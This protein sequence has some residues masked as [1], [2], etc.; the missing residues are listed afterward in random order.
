MTS[1]HGLTPSHHL[2]TNYVS[3]VNQNQHQTQTTHNDIIQWFQSL[4]KHQ[5]LGN[6]DINIVLE[7]L[8][9]TSKGTSL[10]SLL[11]FFTCSINWFRWRFKILESGQISICSPTHSGCSKPLLQALFLLAR[12]AGLLNMNDGVRP[13]YHGIC[14][15]CR[16]LSIDMRYNINSSLVVRNNIAHSSCQM[17]Q[18]CCIMDYLSAISWPFLVPT[19]PR[20]LPIFQAFSLVNPTQSCP[21]IGPWSEHDI[22]RID[23]TNIP[24]YKGHFLSYTP[25]T[26]GLFQQSPQTAMMDP[27]GSSLK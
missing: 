5:S 18:F 8:I 3:R 9:A 25:L 14:N 15:S 6:S 10:H 11:R 20:M 12:L 13:V 7:W 2:V 22:I 21:L 24:N 16:L 26:P 17:S 1:C 27:W 4:I 19:Y 23:I